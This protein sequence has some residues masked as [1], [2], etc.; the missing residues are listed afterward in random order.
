MLDTVKEALEER[1][2]KYSLAPNVTEEQ[3]RKYRK[4]SL[5]LIRFEKK[6]KEIL[7]SHNVHKINWAPYMNF[8]RHI[9]KRSRKYRFGALKIF[10]DASI[11]YWNKL[12]FDEDVLTEIGKLLIEKEGEIL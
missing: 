1:V 2:R 11:L 7:E 5:S 10:V 8:A 9:W 4:A 3:V 6:V 12:G